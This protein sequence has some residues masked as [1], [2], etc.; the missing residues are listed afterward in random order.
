MKKNQVPRP[1]AIAA[2]IQPTQ[3]KARAA[4]SLLRSEGMPIPDCLAGAR[5]F[6]LLDTLRRG[7]A[8]AAAP[9]SIGQPSNQIM[10]AELASAPSLRSQVVTRTGSVST[11]Q[12]SHSGSALVGTYETLVKRSASSLPR[13]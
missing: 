1:R 13:N 11:E 12:P 9:R 6:H 3:T 10:N 2:T 8:K 4:R 5:L 7:S